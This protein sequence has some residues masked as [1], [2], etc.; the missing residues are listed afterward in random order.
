V[1][2]WHNRADV[3][4]FAG[5][6]TLPASVVIRAWAEADFPAIQTLSEA[7]GWPTPR[8]R[9]GEAL[10]AWQRSWPALVAV[11]D[12]ALI[13]FCRALSDGLVTTYIAE[14]LVVPGWRRQGIASALLDVTQRLCPGSRL[15]LLATEESRGF[16]ARMGFRAFAGFRRSWQE[17]AEDRGAS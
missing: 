11:M 1:A 5:A 15:D 17:L 10:A 3:E 2:P 6:L 8:E 4:V 7:E 12:G 14:L 16:Y 13:G 9:P